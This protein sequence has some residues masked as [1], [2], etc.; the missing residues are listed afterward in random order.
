MKKHFIVMIISLLMVIGLY[1]NGTKEG[2]DASG[3]KQLVVGFSQM[4]TQNSWRIAET[5]SIKE[6][7]EKRGIK[8]IYTD[9]QDSTSKQI[10]D[11]E[12]IVA[13]KPDYLLLAPREYEGLVPAL[14]AAKRANVPVILLDRDAAGEAGTDY[15]TLIAADFIWEGKKSAELLAEYFD[16]KKANIVQLTGTPGSS[17]ARD[18]GKGFEDEIAKHSNLTIISTQVGDFNR[19]TAQKTMENI[20]QASGNSIDAVYGHSDEDGIGALQALKAAQIEGVTIVGING[21][22]DA[23]KAI[24]AGEYYATV[25][26]SPFFGPKAFEVIE[27]LEKG[28]N[29]PLFIQ[30]PGKVFD[31]ANVVEN[32]HE[33]F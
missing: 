20:I 2:D 7:A 26:C 28:D 14:E 12:D 30:N 16:G 3:E 32:M 10:S 24:A 29:V 19:S 22:L 9:A 25:Q 4:D 18:R 1:A 17:V 23:M 6:E 31:A 21:Q 8:L 11:V 33:G 5:N 15:V 27:M 13:Q